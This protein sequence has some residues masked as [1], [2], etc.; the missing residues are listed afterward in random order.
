MAGQAGEVVVGL[1][2]QLVV[3]LLVLLGGVGHVLLH[4]LHGG[5]EGVGE[6]GHEASKTG[7]PALDGVLLVLVNEGVGS[8]EAV[9]ILLFPVLL[10]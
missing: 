6:D 8:A 2:D 1:S 9:H 10:Q 4:N 3:V 7:R 5:L